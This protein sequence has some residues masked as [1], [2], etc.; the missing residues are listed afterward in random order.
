MEGKRG[1][2]KGDRTILFSFPLWRSRRD[3]AVAIKVRT[4]LIAETTTYQ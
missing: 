1:K 4:E 3:I 2:E